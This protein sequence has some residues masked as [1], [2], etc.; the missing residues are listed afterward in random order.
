MALN[1][2]RFIISKILRLYSVFASVNVSAFDARILN[3]VEYHESLLRPCHGT[4]AFYNDRSKSWS[5]ELN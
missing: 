4:V 3:V 5:Q 2:S 1:E